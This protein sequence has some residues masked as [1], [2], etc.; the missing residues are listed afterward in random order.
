MYH[1]SQRPQTLNRY[2]SIADFMPNQCR[3]YIHKV[4]FTAKGSVSGRTSE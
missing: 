4:A 3:S 2:P 1:S